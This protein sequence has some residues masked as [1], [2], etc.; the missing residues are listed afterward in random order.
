MRPTTTQ[1]ITDIYKQRRSLLKGIT[2]INI[3]L[4]VCMSVS[5]LCFIQYGGWMTL[6]AMTSILC[7]LI[8]CFYYLR[9]V[10]NTEDDIRQILIESILPYF[11]LLVGGL[12]LFLTCLTHGNIDILYE[13]GFKGIWILLSDYS[14]RIPLLFIALISI[15][16]WFEIIAIYNENTLFRKCNELKQSLWK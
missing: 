9:T 10:N 11:I 12:P 3:I 5:S 15:C 8:N 4:L 2:V 6:V 7:S 13:Y 1:D 16:F 14:L